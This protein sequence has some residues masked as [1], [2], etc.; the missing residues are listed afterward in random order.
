MISYIF[1]F[2]LMLIWRLCLLIDIDYEACNY[3]RNWNKTT[4][5]VYGSLKL[6]LKTHSVIIS[7]VHKQANCCINQMLAHALCADASNSRYSI[8]V[9][10]LILWRKLSTLSKLSQVE[11]RSQITLRRRS[12]DFILFKKV[13]QKAIYLNQIN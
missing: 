12:T 2:F 13:K 11:N 4:V 1:N 10:L 9:T 8:Y 7:S 3:F 5:N 6:C